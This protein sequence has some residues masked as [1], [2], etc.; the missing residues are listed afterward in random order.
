MTDLNLA[1]LQAAVAGS[2]A[3]FRARTELQPVGGEGTPIFPATYE[4]G[5]YATVGYREEAETGR[6][7]AD[8]VVIDSVQ[9]QANRMEL[10]LQDAWEAGEIEIPVIEVSFANNNLEKNIRVTS[11]EAPHRIADAILRD[12]LLDGMAFRSSPLGRRLDNVDNRNA[13]PLFEL[14]PTALVFGLWDS[15]GPKGGLGAKFQRALVSEILGHEVQV[16]VRT[17]S[18]IDPLQIMKDSAKIYVAED[19][20]LLR[21]TADEN[22]AKKTKDKPTQFGKKGKPSEVNHGNV[23]PSFKDGGVVIQRAVQCTV[24]SLPALRR[25]R[26]PLTPDSNP[27]PEIDRAARTALA[28]LGL[29]GAT[30]AR[31]D[32]CDLRSRCQLVPTQPLSWELLDEPGAPPKVFQL[33]RQTAIRLLREAVDAARMAGLPWRQEKLSLTPS[34]ALVELVRSSQQLA[35]ATGGEEA[36]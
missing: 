26:F 31:H 33:N 34:N 35:I 28:A 16:G 20:A 1:T 7:L 19:N 13:T 30:L 17:S 18:R 6:K 23:T 22:L 3:A 5:K 21:W 14:C 29:C 12:S 15:T 10:A 25:L 4:G 2:A 24:I 11:L 8:S 27:A 9:S 36:V 32:G